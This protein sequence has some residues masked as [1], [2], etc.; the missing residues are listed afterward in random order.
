MPGGGGTGQ[1]RDEE[2][3]GP[4]GIPE[5]AVVVRIRSRVR[6]GWLD[7]RTVIANRARQPA[8]VNLSWTLDSDFTDIQE[9][10]APRPKNHHDGGERGRKWKGRTKE[11]SA[12]TWAEMRP[13]AAVAGLVALMVGAFAIANRVSLFE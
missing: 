8:D 2:K 3:T 11:T 4:D 6:A 13:A 5:R 7:E 1:S 10:E 9:A 12:V